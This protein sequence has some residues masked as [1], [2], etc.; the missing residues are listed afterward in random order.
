MTKKNT[1]TRG[2]TFSCAGIDTKT[3]G[4]VADRPHGMLGATVSQAPKTQRH[5]VKKFRGVPVE[6]CQVV[7]PLLGQLF[8]TVKHP[9][10]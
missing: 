3:S 6:L 5:D 8:L 10:L 2:I 1:H 7:R 9:N 4:C